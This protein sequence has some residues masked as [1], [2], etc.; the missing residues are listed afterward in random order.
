VGVAIIFR[1]FIKQKPNIIRI[2][3]QQLAENPIALKQHS[4]QPQLRGI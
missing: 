1:D 4:G 2:D 3:F